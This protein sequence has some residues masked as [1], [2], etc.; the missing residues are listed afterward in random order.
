MY[1]KKRDKR[2]IQSSDWIYE[3]LKQLMTE[4]DYS[5]ITITEIVNTANIGRTTFYRNFDSIDYVLRLRCLDAFSH[6]RAYCIDYYLLN[7]LESRTFLKPF[8]RYWYEHSEIIEL[9]VKAHRENIIKECLA[10][11]VDFFIQSST[12]KENEIICT[13][14]NYFI[15]MRIA[16]CMSI[17]TEWIKNGKDIPPDTLAEIIELQVKES[18]KFTLFI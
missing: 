12:I 10:A 9:L 16:N 1:Q 14:L 15:E 18:Y 5:Q 2:S 13:H 17:L 8:L 4:K 7:P 6:F 3:A 11:E